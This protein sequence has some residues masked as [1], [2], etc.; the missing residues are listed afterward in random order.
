MGATRLASGIKE[1]APVFV[2]AS[3]KSIIAGRQGRICLILHWEQRALFFALRAV[4]PCAAYR[5]DI[6]T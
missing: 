2:N 6:S 3:L 5:E 4:R 1:K